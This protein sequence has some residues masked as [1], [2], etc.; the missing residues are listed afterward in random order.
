MTV[1]E[2]ETEH[3]NLTLTLLQIAEQGIDMLAKHHGLNI[4]LW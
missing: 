4:A 3:D 2:A 1:L